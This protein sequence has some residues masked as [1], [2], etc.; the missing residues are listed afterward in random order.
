MRQQQPSRRS[1]EE[2]NALV[3]EHRRLPA[4]VFNQLRRRCWPVARLGFDD[5]TQAGFLALIRAAELWRPERGAFT[6][7]AVTSIRR[8]MLQE[9]TKPR[10]RCDRL[11]DGE[12]LPGRPAAEPLSAH[13]CRRVRAAVAA[14][15]PHLRVVVE[16]WV[17]QGQ[18]NRATGR[19]LGVSR[20][21]MHQ[22]R[23]Q[24]LADL[25]W[26]LQA[27]WTCETGAAS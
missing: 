27:W 21:R 23:R 18:A 8:R 17:M 1:I 10:L 15:P 6:T 25:R 16:G 13:E 19:T 2:R 24:A 4:W 20:Q 22:L 14:L 12:S 5:A 3:L 9:A 7:N 11:P 26:K